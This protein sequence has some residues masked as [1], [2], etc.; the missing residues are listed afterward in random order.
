MKVSKP[1]P[2]AGKLVKVRSLDFATEAAQITETQ[3]IC[4]DD[5]EIGPFGFVGSGHVDVKLVVS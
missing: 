1:Q 2:V 3:V 5:K 4:Y